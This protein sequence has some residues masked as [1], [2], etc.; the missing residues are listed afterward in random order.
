[1]EAYLRAL[2][3][4]DGYGLRKYVDGANQVAIV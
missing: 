1:V 4:E 2:V 3:L